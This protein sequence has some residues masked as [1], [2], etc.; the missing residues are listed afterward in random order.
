VIAHSTHLIGQG[1][2]DA[3]SGVEN[4]RIKVT[5]ASGI[6][7]ERCRRLNLNYLD[8]QT[9]RLE[10]WQER[11]DEGIKL[12]PHAGEILYRL[13]NQPVRTSS[14]IEWLLN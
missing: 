12:I 13:L 6:S 8:P 11:E 9:I 1:S 10:D 5:L 3:A 7:E 4:L 14:S 2:Y